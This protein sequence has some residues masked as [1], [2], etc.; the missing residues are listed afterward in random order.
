MGAIS[1]GL[2]GGADGTAGSATRQSEI[3]TKLEI[4]PDVPLPALAGRRRLT[5][6]GIISTTEPRTFHL[7]AT[8]YDT[9]CLDLLRS[10]LTL[11]R[12]TGGPDAGWHLKLPGGPKRQDRGSAAAGRR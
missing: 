7:D 5:T 11:R 6:V 1:V 10:K 12:R 2:T 4:P 9:V 3:E 8:Y